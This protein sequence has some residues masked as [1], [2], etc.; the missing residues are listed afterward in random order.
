L[1]LAAVKPQHGP[2]IRQVEAHCRFLLDPD[3]LLERIALDVLH[4]G[5]V[6][7]VS[8]MIQPAGPGWKSP[9]SMNPDRALVQS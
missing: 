7:R 9:D 4:E 1:R 5:E 3:G 8:G 6:E 2:D